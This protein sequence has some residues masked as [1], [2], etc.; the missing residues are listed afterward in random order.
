MANPG[1]SEVVAKLARASYEAEFRA[2]YGNEVFADVEGAFQRMTLA[3]Q[4][5]QLEDADFHAYTSKYDE[6][7]RGRA[8]LS[9]QELRGLALF[10]DPAKGNCASCHPSER[11]PDGAFPL[12]TDYGFVALGVPRNH[13][14]PAN[15]DPR[16]FDLGLCGPLRT[17]LMSRPDLCGRFRTPSLRNV[18]TRHRFMHNGVFT[19]LD[20]VVRFYATRDTSPERWWP[21]GLP[22]DL[23]APAR[24]NLERG[25][26]FG[27]PRRGTPALDEGEIADV[28]AFL[29]TL[30]DEP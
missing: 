23:P 9:E 30:T 26:P 2:L 8:K 4:Q 13:A 18:A 10:N 24:A 11:R 28:V 14:I 25:A 7:L 20:E 27:R 22:D 29:R 15:A 5:Y 3:L 21:R 1:K 12:F 17:D 16:F 6:F 19:R